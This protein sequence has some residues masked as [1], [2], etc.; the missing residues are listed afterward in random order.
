MRLPEFI[1]AYMEEILRIWEYDAK[2]ILPVQRLSRETLRDHVE[3][4][5][6]GIAVEL[7]RPPVGHDR[8]CD[9]GPQHPDCEDSARI[10]GSERH[11]LGADIVHVAAEFRALR[12][13]VIELWVQYNGPPDKDGTAELIRFDNEI[14]VALAQSIEHYALRKQRQGRLFETML[15]S[16][17]DPCYIL[18]LEGNFLYANAA[19]AELCQLPVEEIVGRSFS[20]M[21]LPA[22]Y[23]GKDKL[24]EVIRS[25]EQY[26]SE[27]QVKSPSG[28]TRYFE[29][30]Y[31]PVLDYRGDVEA[32]AGIGHDI[33]HRKE[34]E[35]RIWRHANYDLLTGL[36]NRR[37][38]M[39]RLSQHATHSERT[40]DP[41]AL[42]F[43]D[44]DHF[45]GINDRLGHDA[46]D[47]L[48]KMI[49]QR[50]DSCV[51]QSDTVA[52][53]GGDEFTVLLLDTG[54]RELIHGIASNILAELER[55]FQLGENEASISC[56][57]GIT[58]FPEDAGTAHQLLNDADQAMYVA[59][60]SGRNRLCYFTDVMKSDR[61]GRRQMINDLREAPLS[62][63]LRLFYQ[64][65][66][67]LTSG[68]I[69]KAEALLRWQHPEQGLKL[70]VEFLDLAEESGLM[71]ALEHWVFS[72]AA[73]QSVKWSELLDD[74]FQL[75]INSSPLQ[76]TQNIHSKPWEA[77]LDT[78]QQANTGIAIE[79][80]ENV[81]LSDSDQ[82]A[83]NFSE[84]KEAGVQLALDDFGTGYSSLAYLKR[85]DVNYLKIDQSFVRDDGV[86]S[87]SHA[88]AETIIMMAHKLG[89]QVVAEGVETSEQ[90]DWLMEAGCDFAQGFFFSKPMPAVE[91]EQLLRTGP[92]IH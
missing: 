6:L 65:I 41:F 54:D 28:E 63:Q 80:T 82:L 22:Q 77:H 2:D 11:D 68:R 39:D 17:P 60:H 31:A 75:T 27:V 56:S 33:T 37:L 71:S 62:G 24:Q 67:D 35:S 23:N 52:R 32:V 36:P 78:F 85:F 50:V 18:N 46:G 59:K 51:R 69:V 58:L 91:F 84:L 25:K 73:S 57:I 1:R 53:I 81:F 20:E 40:G 89:L 76:F 87:N 88:I 61:T 43:V 30:V 92:I 34:A 8:F 66:I 83:R 42:L 79:L 13:T 90:R 47:D 26:K 70:P 21:P 5:L 14:D 74:T 48:L 16:L 12:L 72:E 15:S 9:F 10:H 19:M 55:P 49:A 64:P 86:G 29:C 3:E 45:K 38:F 7:E 4:I 44:L